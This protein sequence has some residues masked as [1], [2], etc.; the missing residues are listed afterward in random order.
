MLLKART[1]LINSNSDDALYAEIV[2]HTLPNA[3]SALRKL[4]ST[5][6]ASGRRFSRF[7]HGPLLLLPIAAGLLLST[8]CSHLHRGAETQY[9]YVTAKETFLR[10]RVAAVSNRTATVQN[11]DKLEIL[12]HG[13]RFYHVKTAKDE[14]GWI[15]ERAVATQEVFDG[16]QN[17]AKTAAKEPAVASAVVRDEVNLHLKPGRDTERFYRLA[18]G[19]KLQL[20]ERATLPKPVPGG[21]V[22]AKPQ[23][24]PV[25]KAAPSK[26][27]AAPPGASAET[28]PTAPVPMEDWWLARDSKGRA[29]WLLSRMLDVDAPDTLTRYAEGQ[30]FVGAYVLT[31]VYDPDAEQDNKNIPIYLTVLAPYV[32]GLPYDFDQVRLF[33]WNSKMHRYETGFREKNIEGYLPVKIEMAKDPYGKVPASQTALPTFSYR[34]L[35]ADSPPVTPDP[36]TGLIT[37]GK[38]ISKTYRL[39]GNMVRRIAPPGYHDPAEAHP[40][41]EEK[42]EKRGR[43]R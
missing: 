17:L 22:L 13:R 27:G 8:G 30:K 42:K 5:L 10:D 38:T 41:P 19:D 24:K 23:T 35:A 21:P 31:T 36:G 14:I 40:K 1:R 3:S 11:G 12:E 29:G 9:V 26:S 37:P 15:D 18:E 20:I 4:A 2:L 33:T 6:I 32:A 16:F 34:V 43:R 7:W 28:E 25:K 39:E